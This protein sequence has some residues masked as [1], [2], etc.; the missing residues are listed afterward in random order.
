ML[1][2]VKQVLADER[3][4]YGGV[5]VMIIIAAVAVIG[6]GLAAVFKSK[7]PASAKSVANKIQSTIDSAGK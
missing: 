6:L 4:M 5:E 2:Q 1:Q 3:G 7:L